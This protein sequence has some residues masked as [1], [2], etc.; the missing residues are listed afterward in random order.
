M[1]G[2]TA[3][4]EGSNVPTRELLSGHV[5]RQPSCWPGHSMTLPGEAMSRCAT[6][7]LPLDEAESL[8]VQ[9]H[10]IS[11]SRRLADAMRSRSIAATRPLLQEARRLGIGPTELVQ[12]TGLH[13]SEIRHL[14]AGSPS[15]ME[16]FRPH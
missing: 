14:T 7:R 5:R 10:D 8:R 1:R 11:E 12:V 4:S 13:L 6:C 15:M 16:P 9:L 3:A 2:R